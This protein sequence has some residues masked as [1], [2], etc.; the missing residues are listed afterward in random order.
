MKSL[1]NESTNLEIIERINKLN[2][3]CQGQWGKMSVNQML[4]H[5]RKPLEAAHSELQLKR[6]LIGILFGPIAKK[7]LITQNK[8]FK[9][10]LPTDKKFIVDNPSEFE[11]EKKA[12]IERIQLFKQ[13]GPEGITKEPHSFFGPL[14]PNEWDLLQCKHLDHHLSQ[15]GV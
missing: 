3:S 9:K 10:D 8:P 1:F 12:L 4:A 13:K 2:A 6:N 5:C 11:Q 7:Q 14:T 15:F